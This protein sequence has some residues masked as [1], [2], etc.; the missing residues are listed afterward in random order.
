MTPIELEVDTL[1]VETIKIYNKIIPRI[2]ELC[3]K[4]KRGKSNNAT[5]VAFRVGILFDIN[6]TIL[7]IKSKLPAGSPEERRK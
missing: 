6:T 7:K 1:E 4:I 5:E 3:E 2:K